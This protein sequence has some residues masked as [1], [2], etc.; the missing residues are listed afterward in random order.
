MNAVTLRTGIVVGILLVLAPAWAQD[1]GGGAARDWAFIE[2]LL[3]DGMQD[4]AARQMEAFAAAYPQEA[5]APEAL[6]RAGGIHESLDQ[7][8]AALA[9]YDALLERHATS[10]AAPTALLRKG[11]LLSDAGRLQEAANV[12]RGVLSSYPASDEV[13]EARLGLGESLLGLEQFED[14]G[15]AF[16][17]L[18]G[19]RASAS[20]SARAMFDLGLLHMRT[21][22]DSLAVVHFD[23]IRTRYPEQP[24][25]AFGQLRAATLLEDLDPEAA[26][27]RYDRVLDAFEEPFLRA[28]ARLGLARLAEADDRPRDAAKRY[29]EVAREGG[30]EDQ[31]TTALLGLARTEL[32]AGRAK[33]SR[34]AAEALLERV[35]GHESGLLA[36]GR[37]ALAAGDDDGPT[38]LTTLGREGR[39]AVASPAWSALGAWHVERGDADAALEDYARAAARAETP[40]DRVAARLRQAAIARRAG[41]A[42]WASELGARAASEAEEAAP[43]REGLALAMRAAADAADP[44][45]ALAFAVTLLREF[46][47]SPEAR[48]ARASH[49]LWL[50]QATLDPVAGRKALTALAVDPSMPALER[51]VRTV[52]ILRDQVGDLEAALGEA[53][54]ARAR[55]QTPA[56][57]AQLSLEEG[58]TLVDLAR[59]HAATGDVEAA[60][61]AYRDARSRLA[62]AAAESSDR[63]AAQ[64]E[65]LRLEL[66]LAVLPQEP[67]AVDIGTAPL[68]GGVGPLEAVDLSD[69]A[70]RR[71]VSRLA[72]AVESLEGEARAWTQWRLAELA[73]GEDQGRLDR[74]AAASSTTRVDGLQ[75]AIRFTRSRVLERQEDAEGAAGA[76]RRVLEDNAADDVTS[77]ARYAMAEL[78]RA[79]KRYDAAQPLYDG[80]ASTWPETQKGQRALLLAGDCA[81]FSRDRPGSIARYRDLLERHPGSVYADDARYRLGTAL[82][83]S[84]QPRE[85]REQF[86]ILA[87]AGRS[88]YRGRALFRLAGLEEADGNRTAAKAHWE[89]LLEV[90]AEL[91]LANDAHAELARLTLADGEPEAALRWLDRAPEERRT[92]A[93][94]LALRVRSEAA[95]G[96]LERAGTALATLSEGHPQAADATARARVDLALAQ[97]EAGLVDE[98][99]EHLRLAGAGARDPQL[100]AEAAY[101]RGMV[102]VRA[103][104][105]DAA[106]S[107]FRTAV[108]RAGDS[109]WGAQALFKLGNIASREGRD[110]EARERFTRLVDD[111]PGHGLAPQAL[112]AVASSWRREGRPDEA[113]AVYHRILEE[114]PEAPDPETV[115]SQ[116]AYCHHELGQHEVAIASYGRVMPLLDEEGQAYA[117]FWIAD[118][119]QQLG[120]LEEAAA[121][122]LRIPYLYPGEGQLAVTAQLKA[123]R[124]YEQMGQVDAATRLYEK[125]LSAHGANSQ[126]GAEARKRLDAI[127]Q[128]GREDSR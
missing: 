95:R 39:P 47:T 32:A 14:A 75:R 113:L 122:F 67:W 23:G 18:I 46:P 79:A 119:H 118:S 101:Q 15:R 51:A 116:I 54:A 11:L 97:V 103:G 27:E 59:T 31:V 22:A 107:D 91:A 28:R 77:A 57:R 123:A 78:H 114:Y 49:D 56:E 102:Q 73:G 98:A 37:A 80:F 52:T 87:E 17:H 61:T 104:D 117:Q 66:A 90:D 9:A 93:P 38:L 26:G 88:D 64:G 25:A 81:L 115:L 13:D 85:A 55:V 7:P 72:N 111:H 68:W 35:P 128:Q 124:V 92:S 4:V 1:D 65:L 36:Q 126:W 50:R 82:V 19:G 83:R 42:A 16:R 105:L 109:E 8:G 12:F 121:G 33:E 63:A 53:R 30:T 6:L 60:R 5:R 10:P 48:E 127:A 100:A 58:R 125:V 71:V 70:V 112:R 24:I 69:D 20:V 43:R 94:H 76:L 44:E 34:R 120:R 110:A 84:G 106:V 99:R 40:A 86:G 29:E 89:Q 45:R 96:R 108:D 21:G 41:H 74:L 2:K 62:D 3:G